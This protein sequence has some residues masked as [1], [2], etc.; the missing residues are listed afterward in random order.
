MD[1][2]T[3]QNT[4]VKYNLNLDKKI[5]AKALIVYLHNSILAIKYDGCGFE[6]HIEIIIFKINLR[7][8]II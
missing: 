7:T 8:I 3:K 1:K 5:N 4:G 6:S 2:A